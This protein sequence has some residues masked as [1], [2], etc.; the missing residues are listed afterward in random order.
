MSHKAWALHSQ[1][2]RGFFGILSVALL[3][4]TFNFGFFGFI[5]AQLS[6][7][8]DL[9]REAEKYG[10]TLAEITIWGA[11]RLLSKMVFNAFLS[12]ISDFISLPAE[13]AQFRFEIHLSRS[14][15]KLRAP[16]IGTKVIL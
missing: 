2:F 8:R 1:I 11:P 13:Q 10:K 7:R 16:G 3:V 5:L 9:D 15:I 14:L 4:S 12:Q 6:Q